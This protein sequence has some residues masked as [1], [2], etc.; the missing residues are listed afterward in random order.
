MRT[1]ALLLWL[2]CINSCVIAAPAKE[3]WRATARRPFDT[4]N[5]TQ[6]LEIHDGVLWVSAGQ[7]G[8]SAIRRYDLESGVLLDTMP[9]PASL[10]AEGLTVF[11]DR[12]LLLTWQSGQLREYDRQSLQLRHIHPLGTE[13]WGITQHNGHVWYSDGSDRL[14]H[15]QWQDQDADWRILSV[16]LDGQPVG[17]LNELEW[18]DGEIWANVWQTDNIVRI[19]PGSGEISGVIDLSQLYPRGLRPKS[20]DVLNGIARD[21]DSGDIWVTGKGWP[22]RFAITPPQRSNE[23]RYNQRLSV[24]QR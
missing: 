17:R 5:F 13:G 22:W 23:A 18:I 15:R 20:A 16:T 14:Y 12:V 9:L 11:E 3:Q 19:D 10:F 8:R 7:Y 24:N 4:Q 1:C 2:L 6:G 21:P